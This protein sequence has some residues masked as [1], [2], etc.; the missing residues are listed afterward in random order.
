MHLDFQKKKKYRV[1]LDGRTSINSKTGCWEFIGTLDPDGYG[2][3]TIDNTPYSVSRLSAMIF[4]GFVPAEGL[5]I[6]HKCSS[7]S[8]WNP[9]HLYVGTHKQNMQDVVNAGGHRNQK[10]THCIHGH[11]FTE[12]NTRVGANGSRKCKLCQRVQNNKRRKFEVVS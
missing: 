3:I 12:E 8:C 9:E 4:L 6:L 5:Q 7:K 11:A 1:I 2:R 10:K